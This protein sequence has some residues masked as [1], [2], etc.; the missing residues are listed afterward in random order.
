MRSADAVEAKRLPGVVSALAATGQKSTSGAA[1]RG[2]KTVNASPVR[3]GQVPDKTAKESSASLP[4]LFENP[5]HP[6][7]EKKHSTFRVPPYD[8]SYK[9][10]RASLEDD[11]RLPPTNVARVEELVNHFT[12]AYPA[13]ADNAAVGMSVDVATCPWEVDHRLARVALRARDARAGEVG[14]AVATDLTANVQFNPSTTSAWRLIG[15]ETGDPATGA[16]GSFPA[17]DLRAGSAVTALYEIVPV[18][19]G[20]P[21]T[22]APANLFTVTV[23]YRDTAGGQRETIKAV[24]RD[25]GA[26]FDRSDEDFHFA[27]AVA[28]F[29]ML[30]R[31]CK[32]AGTATYADVMRWAT[33]GKGA[34]ET[35][36]RTEF[37]DLAKRA[38]DLTR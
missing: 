9:H 10:I 19:G 24:A 35:R 23:R 21:T 14:K 36:Q 8:W 17:S 30:L 22:E 2:P 37:I 11:N 34:D 29:G 32:F 13:P 1:P 27:S 5:F 33:Q 6:A 31:D 4:K 15:Y 25:T 38:R 18:P 7:A 16:G 26:G 20:G 12:Y 3:D 28:A